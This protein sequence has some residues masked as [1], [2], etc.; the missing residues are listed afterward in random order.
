MIQGCKLQK[1]VYGGVRFFR[2]IIMQKGNHIVADLKGCALSDFCDSEDHVVVL[3]KG[4]SAKIKE[5]QLTELGNYYHFFG[6]SALTSVICLAESHI[7]FHSWPEDDYV[8]LD[9]FVCNL[10]RDNSKAAEAMY[11]YFLDFFQPQK[12][13]K[14][15]LFR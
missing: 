6:A 11:Q 3:K 12:T 10:N 14:Q 13:K 5:L 15:V 1:V 7:N 8:Q 9:I 4:I 2:K